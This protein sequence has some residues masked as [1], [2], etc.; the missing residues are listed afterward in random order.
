M[1]KPPCELNIFITCMREEE[2]LKI[3]LPRLIGILDDYGIT[4]RILVVDTVT[5]MDGTPEVCA[6]FENVDYVPT[7]GG[8]DGYGRAVRTGIGRVNAQYAILMDGDLSHPPEV[9]P[10]M[11]DLRESHDMVIASRYTEGGG[12]EDYFLNHL[13]SR[14]LNIFCSTLLGIDCKDWSTSFKLYKAPQIKALPLACEHF[15]IHQEIIC[16]LHENHPDFKFAEVP[17][18][19]SKRVHGSSTRQFSYGFSIAKTIL[20][21]RLGLM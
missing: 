16:K 10:S 8:K 13:M 5:P 15:D 1:T 4:Y 7:D 20:K 14:A 12:S 9:I 6:G 17:M 19:F 21:L 18:S 3:L 11:L 2:N